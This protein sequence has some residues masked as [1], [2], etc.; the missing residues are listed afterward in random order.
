MGET[1]LS[2]FGRVLK[3]N[4]PPPHWVFFRLDIFHPVV[5]IRFLSSIGDTYCSLDTNPRLLT[6]SFVERSF[7]FFPRLP[8]F[9]SFALLFYGITAF[10]PL[11]SPLFRSRRA[12]VATHSSP[13]VYFSFSLSPF[14]SPLPPVVT[15]H[16]AHL[17]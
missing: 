14:T 11:S 5:R 8:S 4:F 10:P 1:Q 7:S 16:R 13:V 9:F 17:Y 15:R 3:A 2:E 12:G 6:L